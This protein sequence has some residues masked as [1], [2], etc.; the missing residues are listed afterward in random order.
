MGLGS[1]FKK[2]TKSL[3][4]GV[5]GSQLFK[6][7]LGGGEDDMA[8]QQDAAM[9]QQ[10]EQMKLQNANSAFQNV[11]QFEDGGSNMGTGDLRRKRQSTGTYSGGLGLK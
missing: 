8:R 7:I 2:V 9:R 10:A 1:F 11:V 6:G 5:I 4:L 3:G